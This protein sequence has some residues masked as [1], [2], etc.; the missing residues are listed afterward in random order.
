LNV[1]YGFKYNSVEALNN[2]ISIGHL[3]INAIY[4]VSMTMSVNINVL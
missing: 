1:N 4:E 2:N 3:I